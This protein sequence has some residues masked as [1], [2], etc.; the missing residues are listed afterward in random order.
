M[1]NQNHKNHRGDFNKD[2]NLPLIFMSIGVSA[3]ILLVIGFIVF[4][5]SNGSDDSEIVEGSECSDDSDCVSEYGENHLCSNGECYFYQQNPSGDGD[6]AD[7]NGKASSSFAFFNNFFSLTGG[8]VDEDR[9]DIYYDDGF[10]GIGTKNPSSLLHIDGDVRAS[11]LC[12]GE[13]DCI[14]DWDDL[15]GNGDSLWGMSD[16]N[17][18]FNSGNVGIGTTSPSSPLHVIGSSLFEGSVR[19]DGARYKKV[20]DYEVSSS[21][22]SVASDDEILHLIYGGVEGGEIIPV[23]LPTIGFGSREK[24]R[25][26]TFIA[27]VGTNSDQVTWHIE[28]PHSVSKINGQDSVDLTSDYQSLTIVAFSETGGGQWA[29]IGAE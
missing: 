14:D 9:E 10:V 21:G 28:T 11:E 4:S 6:E 13:D 24:G 12:I 17:I 5:P 3:V 23:T 29:I 2:T 22:I 25:S 16:S 18:Y 15:N 8:A 1:K 26:L 20:T 27:G 7:E 19:Y